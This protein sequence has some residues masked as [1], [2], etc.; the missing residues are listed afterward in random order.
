MQEKQ[1]QV[2][3]VESLGV[4]NGFLL[5][6]H[7]RAIHETV[8]FHRQG[9]KVKKLLVNTHADKQFA[10]LKTIHWPLYWTESIDKYEYL[11]VLSL[12][13]FFRLMR[14]RHIKHKYCVSLRADIN[15]EPLPVEDKPG[16]I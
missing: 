8:N 16:N 15:M 2:G 4:S 12:F 11:N 10:D 9:S 1:W 13:G 14:P 6:T 3:V 5:Q 7:I